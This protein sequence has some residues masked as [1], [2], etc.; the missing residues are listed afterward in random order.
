[1]N[2]T[3]QQLKTLIVGANLIDADKFEKI[4][5]ES[6]KKKSSL[7]D[8]IVEG[9]LL[10]D[11]QLGQVIANHLKLPFVPLAKNAITKEVLNIIPEI[12][13]KK[14]Q[15]IAF[16]KDKT[17]VKVATCN[18]ENTEVIDFIGKKTGD[19]PQ[20][21][22]ATPRA[23]NE[24]LRLYQKDI[25]QTFDD[26]LAQQVSAA[27]GS[28]DKEAPVIKIVDL[29]VQYAYNNH[30][31]DIH[32]EPED[33]NSLVRFRIDGILHDI[34]N[35]P[36]ELHNQV[37][38]RIK[39]LSKMR[40]DEHQMAQDGKF[41][42]KLPEENLDLRVSI[43][44]IVRGE[45]VVLRLLSSNSRQY[46]LTDLGM[47]DKDLQKISN[48][49]DKPYGMILS[50]G[51]T[52]SGKTTTMY[53]I[54]K[55]L[56]KRDVNIMT[57]EDPVEYD[58]QGVN[59]IQVNPKTNLTFA[60]GLRAILRQDPNVI[61]VG[62]IRDEETAGIA[63]NA[64]MTGHLVLSTVHTNNAATTIPRLFDM[65]I[66]PFLVASSVNVIIAQRLVRKICDRCK[67]SNNYTLADLSKHFSKETIQ[68]YFG[69]KEEIHAYKGEGCS[70]CHQSGYAGRLGIYEVMEVSE[71]IK[72]LIVA[73]ADANK[74]ETKA[75]EEGMVTLVE[76]AL[77]KVARGVTTIEE[78]LRATKEN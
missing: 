61:L 50:T 46:S 7:L 49:Y 75:K 20:V 16:S 26:L 73:K 38:T 54:L 25:K 69:T 43:V 62:E 11:D 58:I 10:A 14:Q 23:I 13:A 8:A 76:D 30:A 64:A 4:T 68:K 66:E 36:I 34:L 28:A 31:S 5:S 24:A 57:V 29:L 27:S 6:E 53:S 39:V 37:V 42:E 74:I 2:L 52:G 56:N 17:G 51:P 44:P 45:K 65:D 77:D 18:P 41:Q 78:V 72:E 32:I 15:I 33:K 1:M 22:F 40:T 71:K 67:K 12:V 21:Y 55:I 63:V 35:I 59:Q 47:N 48:A 9:G 60:S 19:K 3:N 70:V